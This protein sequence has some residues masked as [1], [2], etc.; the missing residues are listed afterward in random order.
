MFCCLSAFFLCLLGKPFQC[1]LLHT[2]FFWDMFLL[3]FTTNGIYLWC[4]AFS[5]SNLTLVSGLPPQETRILPPLVPR[6][7][8]GGQSKCPRMVHPLNPPVLNRCWLL[9]KILIR[10]GPLMHHVS[11]LHQILGKRATLL[12]KVMGSPIRIL[13]TL[14]NKCS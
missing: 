4:L 7:R 14:C 1:K 13:G 9:P 3:F 10:P 6:R 8:R 11:K 12:S 2:L 5:C